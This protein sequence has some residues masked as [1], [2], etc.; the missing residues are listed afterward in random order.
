[1][2]DNYDIIKDFLVPTDI[3]V[4]ELGPTRSKIILEPLEQGF[5]HTL[6]NALRR[7]MLSSMPGTAVSEVKIEGVLH[8]YT[9]IEGVQEDVIDIL[10]NLKELSVRLLESEE[11]ELKI[12]KKSKGQ[13]VAGDIDTPAGVEIVNP[14]HLIATVTDKGSLNMVLKVTRGRG[15]VPVK[16][17]SEDEGQETGLLR[18]DAT[19]S[20]I[21]RVSY[22][23]EDARVEQR[24][25]LDR[26][27][28]DIDTDGTLDAE[29]VLRISATIL[30]HQ[31]SA[32]AELGRL[33]EVIEEK[34][35]TLIDP[36]M[37][38]PVD[39]LELTV[40]SA[41]CLKAENVNFIGDLV[42]RM[43]SDLLRTPNLGKKSL[44]EIK[45]VLASRGLSLGLVLEHWPHETT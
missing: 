45:E 34:E 32:F 23:V 33:E 6:G 3:L 28:I 20:P 24:T 25:N 14:D 31:L 16:P 5:G 11:A 22:T 35:E 43:E 44:N 29:E 12:S 38:R 18:L 4:E 26:L 39:E 41:N 13:V 27:I 7:I 15:F 21:K 2:T 42:T 30:Q 19:Y 37:M 36:V 1:M 40:R 17:L 8:E 9:T 10:L